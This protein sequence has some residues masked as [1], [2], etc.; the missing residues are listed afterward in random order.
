LMSIVHPFPPSGPAAFVCAQAGCR[1][2]QDALVRQHEGLVHFILRQRVRGDV[3]Y[4]DLLQEGRIAL[5]QAILHFDPQRG[6]TFSTYA[7]TAIRNQMWRAVKRD[8]RPQG[9][10][11]TLVLVNPL[12]IA[13]EGI[14]QDEI[15]TALKPSRVFLNV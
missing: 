13:E 2:C 7:G 4:E 12:A 1:A 5:W 3:P 9:R 8:N 15:H 6:V 10:L 14:W 11:S